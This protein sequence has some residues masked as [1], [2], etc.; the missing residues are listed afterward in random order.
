MA[1]WCDM[2]RQFQSQHGLCRSRRKSNPV[3]AAIKDRIGIRSVALTRFACTPNSSLWERTAHFEHHSFSV[4]VSST[5]T[6]PV[7]VAKVVTTAGSERDGLNANT[8]NDA[9]FLWWLNRKEL[10]RFRC[11]IRSLFRWMRLTI[12]ILVHRA[13][14]AIS[15]FPIDAGNLSTQRYGRSYRPR[16]QFPTGIYDGLGHMRQFAVGTLQMR[17]SLALN[18]TSRSSFRRIWI[19]NKALNGEWQ[20]I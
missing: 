19:K 1:R 12:T 2:L 7:V 10:I 6:A 14:L 3:Y 4:F 17:I 13:I 20:V 18:F 15:N 16:R 11:L 9:P 8:A 5:N